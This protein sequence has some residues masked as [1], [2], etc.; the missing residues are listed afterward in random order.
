MP[1][2]V[3][4]L[5]ARDNTS[6][7]LLP[8]YRFTVKQYHRMIEEGI[9]TDNDRVELLQGWIVPKMAQSHPHAGTVTRITRRL[10]PVLPRRWLLRVQSAITLPESEPEP[11]LAIVRGP[12]EVYFRRHPRPLDIGLSIEVAGSSLLD[13]RRRKGEIYAL[14]RIPH[15]WVV[16]LVDRVVEVYS[17]PRAGKIAGY[18]SQRSYGIKESVPLIL[19]G[20]VVRKIRV[21]ELLP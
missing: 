12:E 18:R 20:R 10:T 6:G 13:D 2:S 9:L 5:P 15:Y 21:S 17:R 16:N 11:D 1:V 14:A 19:A 3:A 8:V 7:K 4:I